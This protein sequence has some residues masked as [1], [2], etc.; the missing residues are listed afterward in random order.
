VSRQS[1]LFPPSIRS[2]ILMPQ[3]RF[4][5]IERLARQNRSSAVV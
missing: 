1:S 3:T 5:L 2:G 4:D